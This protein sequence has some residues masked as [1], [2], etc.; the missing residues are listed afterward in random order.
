MIERRHIARML[1]ALLLVLTVFA[2]PRA[3]A[4]QEPL[5]V[6]VA[7]SLGASNIE[8]SAL[9]R[10][11]QGYSVE[12]VG[13]RLVPLNQAL[14]APART[15]FDKLVLGL[16][17]EQVGRYWIDRRIRDSV[18]SPRTIPSP[19]LIVRVVAS[20]PGA[21]GYVSIARNALPSQVRV[22][23]VDGKLPGERDYPLASR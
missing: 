5:L 18:Q 19:E 8:L 9:R 11:F 14:Q 22:L 21:I 6:V 1:G 16:T 15:Q 13:K 4:Q 3:H 23:S 12:L 2:W 20:I 7:A 10:A 17:P